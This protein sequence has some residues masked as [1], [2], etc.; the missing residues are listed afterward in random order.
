MAR[1]QAKDAKIGQMV[2]YHQKPAVVTFKSSNSHTIEVTFV[3]SA[4]DDPPNVSDQREINYAEFVD[5][6]DADFYL[7]D[8]C[9]YRTFSRKQDEED[10]DDEMAKS[11][12]DKERT[13]KKLV[14]AKREW[15]EAVKRDQERWDEL[16]RQNKKPEESDDRLRHLVDIF[17]PSK[18]PF[19]KNNPII[20]D[21]A[22]DFMQEMEKMMIRNKGFKL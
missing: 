12:D 11:W 18:N 10:V 9:I 13:E 21:K 2:F 16:C 22:S 17:D 4:D 15:D 7:G 20:Q 5:T 6:L 3:K 19:L 8:D 14:E 1:I